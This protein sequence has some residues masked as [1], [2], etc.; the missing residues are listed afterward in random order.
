MFILRK[1]CLKKI[2]EKDRQTQDL[3]EYYRGKSENL[4]RDIANLTAEKCELEKRLSESV[5]GLTPKQIHIIGAR[6]KGLY[7]YSVCRGEVILNNVRVPI[8]SKN[9]DYEAKK[10]AGIRNKDMKGCKAVRWTL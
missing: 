6:K 5:E 9:Y 2:A 4:L 1:S 3:R 7:I 10:L 8:S